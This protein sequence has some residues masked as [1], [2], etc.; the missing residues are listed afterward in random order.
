M[1]GKG[2]RCI[3]AAQRNRMIDGQSKGQRAGVNGGWTVGLAAACRAGRLAVN[4]ND[5]MGL[6]QRL[7]HR[8]G[9][10]R[11]AHEDDFHARFRSFSALASS[12]F[13]FKGE[14]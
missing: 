11:R 2:F 14:R 5:F 12:I 7:Q 10:I 13:R 6:M 8:N 3:F 1:A 4:R 9:K